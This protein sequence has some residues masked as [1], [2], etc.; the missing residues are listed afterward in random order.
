LKQL[1]PRPGRQAKVYDGQ[2]GFAFAAALAFPQ[3]FEAAY[4]W[5]EATT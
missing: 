1:L 4:V 2:Q 5:A 3:F